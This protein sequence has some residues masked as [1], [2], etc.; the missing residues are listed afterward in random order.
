MLQGSQLNSNQKLHSKKIG[1][2]KITPQKYLNL[3]HG[4]AK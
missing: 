3:D 1:L 4:A 2:L